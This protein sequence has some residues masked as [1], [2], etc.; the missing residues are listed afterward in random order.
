MAIELFKL[1]GTIM[2]DN[3][4]ANKSISKTEKQAESVGG[5]LKEGIKTAAKWGAGLAAGA[6]VA[7]VGMTKV[8]K[9][10]A[11][12]ADEIDKMS[13]K[14]SMSTDEYQ[15]LAYAAELSGTNMST[16]QKAQKK[17]LESGSKLS[18]TDALKQC[19]DASN[20]AQAATEM[21][22]AK[23]AQELLPMLNQGSKGIDEMTNK[24]DE[25]GLVMDE[26]TVKAGAKLN[27]T[28]TTLQSTWGAAKNQLGGALMPIVNDFLNIIIS[29]MPTV[30]SLISTLSPIL[31]K[32]FETLLPPL[33]ELINQ[34]LPL[35]A[36]LLNALMPIF[37]LIISVIN[38]ILPL[39]TTG[40]IGAIKILV[41]IIESIATVTARVFK[42][43]FGL[44]KPPINA[45]IDAVNSV[46]KSI[47]KLKIPDWVPGVGGKSLD[48]PTFKKLNVGINY[49]PEND[50]PAI[51][52]EGEAVLTKQQA[53][54]WR[55]GGVQN[56][57]D[58]I[59]TIEKLMDMLPSLIEKGNNGLTW[60]I[61][62][63]EFARMVKKNA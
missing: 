25:L 26:K 40:L 21:F 27:D 7:I 8:A 10:S 2:V 24:A 58:V 32:V 9:E 3:E 39:I 33:K 1:V 62:Q 17:L 31:K 60:N 13:Q 5:K 61:N 43:L 52:H 29:L 11:K 42:S 35:I 47:N 19:A 20:S 49:V 23:T 56:N 14:L 6:G 16:M 57:D 38:K 46:I 28:F 22:G 55:K 45:I 51:L 34:L 18:L 15:K 37:N 41:P 12:N 59:R 63:R 30:K 4:K 36:P 53:Y 48:I 54:L 44:I 50:Y